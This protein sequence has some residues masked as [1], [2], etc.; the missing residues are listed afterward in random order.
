MK[1]LKGYTYI[2]GIAEIPADVSLEI[3]NHTT[4]EKLELKENG[5]GGY[6]AKLSNVAMHRLQ[7]VTANGDGTGYYFFGANPRNPRV[8]FSVKDGKVVE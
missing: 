3:Y 7:F 6:A 2:I 5:M 4:G 1:S 8:W